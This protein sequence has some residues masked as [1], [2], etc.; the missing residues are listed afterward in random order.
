M[1]I[2]VGGQFLD[3]Y[4]LPQNQAARLPNDPQGIR[5]ILQLAKDL[6]V[7]LIVMEATG[8]LE[9]PLALECGLHQL[10]TAVMN[11]RQIRDFA[12][13]TGRLAK[14]DAIDAHIIARFAF[15][16]RPDARP[17]PDP[18]AAHLKALLARRKQLI[19]MRTAESL[20]LKR[21]LDPLLPSLHKHIQFLSQELDD[22]DRKID[23]LIDSN[24]LWKDK[25]LLLRNVPG[26]G[27]VSSF[28]LVGALPELGSLNRRQIAALLGVAPLNR[29]SGRHRGRRSIWGGRAN[30]RSALYMA[31]MSARVHNPPI[32]AFY[33]QLVAAGKPGKVALVASMRKLL[34]MLNAMIRDGASWNH[35]S[36]TSPIP[37]PQHSC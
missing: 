10:P 4:V 6:N 26:V 32:K 37:L 18:Q 27:P 20:R 3:L 33:E 11:P 31:T 25:L 9:M 28:T 30:I 34:T 22:L 13:S 7:S 17:L 24:I 19:D 5:D 36:R 15:T 8:G 29:D 21:A 12:R 14:T 35:S 2:D 1:G 16:L 23:D